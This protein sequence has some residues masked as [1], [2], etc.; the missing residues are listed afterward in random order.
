MNYYDKIKR[1]IESNNLVLYKH[2][3]NFNSYNTI[4]QIDGEYLLDIAIKCNSIQIAKYLIFDSDGVHKDIEIAFNA[5]RLRRYEILSLMIDDGLFLDSVLFGDSFLK[6]AINNTDIDMVNLLLKNGADINLPYY[7]GMT[8]LMLSVMILR[9]HRSFNPFPSDEEIFDP[10]Y[11]EEDYDPTNFFNGSIDDQFA[12]F[13]ILIEADASVE[14]VD[15]KGMSVLEHCYKNSEE[16]SLI[17]RKISLPILKKT[18]LPVDV[19]ENVIIN[20]L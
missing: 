4:E 20:F 3:M 13:K 19:V 16:E 8:P 12:I 9:L 18:V 5:A 6:I 2:I 11:N 15:N 17:L 7:D 14:N 10:R 1:A